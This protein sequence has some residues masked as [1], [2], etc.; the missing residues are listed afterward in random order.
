MLR[1]CSSPEKGKIVRIRAPSQPAH[2]ESRSQVGEQLLA[3]LPWG[4]T[5]HL[6]FDALD[7]TTPV[8]LS[9]RAVSEVIRGFIGFDGLLLSDDLSMQALGGSL[10]E[11]AARALA[12]GC[13]VALHCNGGID[14]MR[15][16]VG[17]IGPLGDA[18]RRRFEAGRETLRRR[19]APFGKAALAEASGRLGELLPQW[20]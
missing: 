10:G 20:G 12:A 19:R 1:G 11:R 8:T 7:V 15:D 18:A 13:D 2:S 9:A 17:R 4:M 6:L 3:D 5:A 14:E 16:I